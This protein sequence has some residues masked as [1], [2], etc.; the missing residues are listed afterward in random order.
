LSHHDTPHDPAGTTE[1]RPLTESEAA[2]DLERIRSLPK[3]VGVLLLVVGVGG[4]LLP[5]PVGSPFVL[6]GGVVLWPSLFERLEIK[7]QRRFPRLHRRS[8]RQLKRFVDD[9]ERRYPTRA[10]GNEAGPGRHAA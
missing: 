2:E 4:L 10:A 1:L 7:F 6:M 8:M 3:E 5:G 9:L